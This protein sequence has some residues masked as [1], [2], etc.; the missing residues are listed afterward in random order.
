M[1][2]Y[3]KKN[4]ALKRNVFYFSNLE[5]QENIN[6]LFDIFELECEQLKFRN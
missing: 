5:N 3:S 1:F 6:T 4:N 2:V